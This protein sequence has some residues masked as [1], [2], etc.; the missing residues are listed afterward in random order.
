LIINGIRRDYVIWDLHGE[1]AKEDYEGDNKKNYND[2]IQSMLHDIGSS[3]NVEDT[4]ESK[5]TRYTTSPKV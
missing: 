3:I 5:E 4:I 2:G 1:R